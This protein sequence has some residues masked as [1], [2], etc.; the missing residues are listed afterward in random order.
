MRCLRMRYSRALRDRPRN[1]AACVRFP[2][3]RSSAKTIAARSRSSMLTPES[4]TI[5][6]GA[7]SSPA[8][9]ISACCAGTVSSDTPRKGA[10]TMPGSRHGQNTHNPMIPRP[11][12][13]RAA[14]FSQ[15][16]ISVCAKTDTAKVL[17]A[18]DEILQWRPATG[19]VAIIL[20]ILLKRL[21]L[22]HSDGRQPPMDPEP[23]AHAQRSEPCAAQHAGN[24]VSRFEA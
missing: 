15:R 10:R 2:R 24:M 20:D 9:R 1:R 23:S 8:A 11:P 4:G 17:P 18:G 21:R 7:V 22:S 12:T 14:V 13:A 6:T 3:V 16:A 19:P 5:S